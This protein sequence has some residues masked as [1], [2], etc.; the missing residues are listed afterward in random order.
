VNNPQVRR[1]I[2]GWISGPSAD[3]EPVQAGDIKAGDM[4][5]HEG[6]PVTVTATR[7][8]KYWIGPEFTDGVAIDW[9]SPNRLGRMFRRETDTLERLK[10]EP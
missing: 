7:A 5:L 8:S 3:P 6:I 4:L 1:D 9:E 10:A 2:G